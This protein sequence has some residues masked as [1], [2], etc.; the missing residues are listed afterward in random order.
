M[1][2]LVRTGGLIRGPLPTI[3]LKLSIV[4]RL[5]LPTIGACPMQVRS[6]SSLVAAAQ[7]S[8]QQTL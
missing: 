6:K 8:R 4:R 2:E 3:E 7:C 1:L 5:A